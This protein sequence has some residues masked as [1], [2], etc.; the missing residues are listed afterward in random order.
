[1]E[2]IL[3]AFFERRNRYSSVFYIR[4]NLFNFGSGAFLLKGNI[5]FKSGKRFIF[6]N[7]AI[8]LIT[9]VRTDYYTVSLRLSSRGLVLQKKYFRVGA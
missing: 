8:P 4:N 9:I 7:H 1:M 2:Q 3:Q 6:E 5:N